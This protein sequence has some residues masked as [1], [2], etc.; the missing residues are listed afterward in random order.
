LIA[1]MN[2]AGSEGALFERLKNSAAL[3]ILDNCEHV[4]DAAATLAVRLLDA[5]PRVRIL[6]TSQVPLDVEGEAVF[7]LAPL[8]L[9]DAVELFGRRATRQRLTEDGEP[10]ADVWD[11]GVGVRL[12]GV[13]EHGRRRPGECGGEEPVAEVGLGAAARAEVVRGAADRDLHS[14][15]CVGG[16]EVPGHPAAQRPLLGVCRVVAVLGE[17]AA[18]G[19][20]VHVDVLHAHQPGAGG[21]GGGEHARLQGGEL[22]RPAV[23]GRVEGLV[24]DMGALADSGREARVA[25]V[26]PD[27]LD[28]VGHRGDAGTINHADGLAA[29]A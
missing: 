19:S 2:V 18:G 28:A 27:H 25:G 15:G 21:F 24:H 22:F 9:S 29:A 20:P 11:V 16:E 17:R 5:G 12:V 6:C 13:A 3:V 8:A 26:A 4:L 7:E 14:S 1:A 10:F 23:I